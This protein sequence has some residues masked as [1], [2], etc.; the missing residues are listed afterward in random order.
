MIYFHFILLVV[1][2]GGGGGIGS[3]SGVKCLLGKEFLSIFVTC[4]Y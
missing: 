2:G 4:K 3:V 1:V